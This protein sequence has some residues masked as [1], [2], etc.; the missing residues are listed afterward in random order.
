[1]IAAF[2]ALIFLPLS[3][4]PLKIS[5]C[6][7]TRPVV[8]GVLDLQDSTYCSEQPTV[9]SSTPVSYKFLNRKSAYL[10]FSGYQCIRWSEKKVI[11]WTYFEAQDTV[12]YR[13][14]AKVYPPEC[15]LTVYPPYHCNGN[16]MKGDDNMRRYIQKPIGDGKRFNTVVHEVINCVTQRVVLKAA[17]PTCEI[18]SPLGPLKNVSL[19]DRVAYIND[20]VVVGQIPH[21]PPSTCE[22]TD[23]IKEGV[24]NMSKISDKIGRIIDYK[25][26]IEIIF[27][28]TETDKLC[29]KNESYFDVK[30]VPNS[31]ITVAALEVEKKNET[32]RMTRSIRIAGEPLRKN[33]SM[34]PISDSRLC[35]TA[36][37]SMVFVRKC[38]PQTREQALYDESG[39]EFTY[40]D[41]E[42][43]ELTNSSMCVTYNES[44][45]AVKLAQC[46]DAYRWVF[47]ETQTS[48]QLTADAFRLHSIYRDN[49]LCLNA[50]SAYTD[51]SIDSP[52]PVRVI[53]CAYGNLKDFWYFQM[54]VFEQQ[55]DP[56]EREMFRIPIDHLD[57]IDE[58]TTT[59]AAP[60]VAAGD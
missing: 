17:C 51:I 41:D 2:F 23:L 56:N 26:Q 24:G 7:C 60:P 52:E 44:V 11:S 8:R 21:L 50:P 54:N 6:N 59:S 27:N 4:A 40:R 12:F 42:L 47:N 22:E 48:N 31:Y 10:E 20:V 1:M 34:R 18:I 49:V 37:D 28:T 25:S 57:I 38:K 39:Q 35:L 32:S 33:G 58:T 13:D 29:N 45:R 55:S 19:S 9:V 3:T 5:V 53:P 15:W 36:I 30:G 46:S 14:V 43:L 16:E